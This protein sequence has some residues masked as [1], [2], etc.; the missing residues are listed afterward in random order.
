LKTVKEVTAAGI[1]FQSAKNVAEMVIATSRE[2]FLVVCQMHFDRLSNH[3]GFWSVRVSVHR[4]VV[5]RLRPQFF[6]DFTKFCMPLRNV[7]VSNAI[8]SGTNRK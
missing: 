3:F 6:T 7:V 4:S 8:V 2:G 1:V 5:E